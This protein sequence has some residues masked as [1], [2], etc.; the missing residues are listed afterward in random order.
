MLLGGAVSEGI[1]RKELLRE[2]HTLTE[3]STSGRHPTN[4]EGLERI[5]AACLLAFASLV[6]NYILSCDVSN[7]S[8]FQCGLKTSDS[9]RLL[10]AFS[11]RWGLLRYLALWT[12]QLLGY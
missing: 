4:K 9:P 12:E 2:N 10:Q 8:A 7:S 3:G 1:F 11:T 6:D 5:S